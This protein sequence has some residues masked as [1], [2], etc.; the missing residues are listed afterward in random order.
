[1]IVSI[2]LTQMLRWNDWIDQT[3]FMMLVVLNSTTVARRSRV[4]SPIA[5]MRLRSPP[6]TAG[7][8]ITVYFNGVSQT[9]GLQHIKYIPSPSQDL[10]Q[11]RILQQQ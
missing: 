4:L 8:N 6:A 1:M 2:L 5:Q 9:M 11:K 3:G 7:D 10:D